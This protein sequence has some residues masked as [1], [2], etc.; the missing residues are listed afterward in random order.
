MKFSAFGSVSCWRCCSHRQKRRKR[1]PNG[2]CRAEV[3]VVLC[4]LLNIFPI[5]S[6]LALQVHRELVVSAFSIV[7]IVVVH[8]HAQHR[9]VGEQASS[10]SS[11]VLM[12]RLIHEPQALKPLRELNIMFVELH[13]RCSYLLWIKGDQFA[14]LPH[15]MPGHD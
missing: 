3:V 7:W 1:G 8:P 2:F 11:D 14:R 4:A 12:P 5:P 9:I 10:P 13:R 6:V 15:W